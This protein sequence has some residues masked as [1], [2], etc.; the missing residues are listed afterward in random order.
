MLKK[1]LSLLF[2]FSLFLPLNELKTD[3]ST[4]ETELIRIVINQKTDTKL[5]LSYYVVENFSTESRGIFLALPKNQGGV[6]TDYK[7]KSVQRNVEPITD[8]KYT[9]NISS[10]TLPVENF[11]FNFEIN[12]ESNKIVLNNSGNKIE[13]PLNFK[14]EPYDELK[15]LDQFRFRVGKSDK[16]LPLGVFVYKLDLE[17]ALKPDY[18]YNLTLLQ[19]WTENVNKI[20]VVQNGENLCQTKI[21]CTG[22]LTKIEMFA[23]KSKLPIDGITFTILPYIFIL[24]IISAV[25][26]YSWY[27]FAKDNMKGLILDRPEFEPPD[28]K[29]WEADYLIQEGGITIKDTLLSYILW[30]NTHKYISFKPD[31]KTQDLKEKDRTLLITI[32]KY[33]PDLLPPI[34]N[35][36]IN[37][38]AELGMKKGVLASKINE[39]SD[40]ST[41]NT[42]ILKGLGKYYF[43]KPVYHGE[44]WVIVAAFILFFV[45][46]FGF[47]ILQSKF[48]IGKSYQ[49]L[50]IFALLSS[51]IPA[52]LVLKQW[53]K[54]NTEGAQ[55]RAYCMRYKY[56]IQKVETLKLDFSNNP[57]EGVQYYLKAV[58]F[59]ASFGLLAQFG[60]YFEKLVPNSNEIQTSNNLFYSYSAVS[61]Y[62]PPSSSGGSSGGGGGGF[63]GGGGSW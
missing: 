36:T 46:M 35:K 31:P 19:D 38:I 61:F 37:Q 45:G 28:L 32:L 9:T 54:V 6:W 14:N 42:S 7:L 18:N 52:I 40:G 22:A 29:P 24:I 3:A 49:S 34:F 8:F 17:I 41:L 50:A 48:L 27:L 15:E 20:E 21:S 30:L 13:S 58:A 26:V 4:N 53:G 57:T 55:L 39:G 11:N 63:S 10:Y 16:I 62:V 59:A 25:A 44:V 56:Y 5:D 23:G 60:K 51:V 1:I 33:L 2:I 12:N 47:G 43:Q